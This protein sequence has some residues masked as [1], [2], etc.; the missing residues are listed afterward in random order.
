M[1]LNASRSTCSSSAMAKVVVGSEVATAKNVVAILVV[2]VPFL[3]NRHQSLLC[4]LDCRLKRQLDGEKGDTLAANRWGIQ[5]PKTVITSSPNPGDLSH[6]ETPI[7]L[8]ASK[9]RAPARPLA[10]ELPSCV[11]LDHIETRLGSPTVQ[12]KDR[13]TQSCSSWD[14][15]IP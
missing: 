13:D 7:A 3:D 9:E 2:C 11:R 8:A 1:V 14:Q 10:L 15:S 12:G 4:K 6:L 5:P